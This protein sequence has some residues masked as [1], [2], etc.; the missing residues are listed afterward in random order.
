MA[1]VQ[2]QLKNKTDV[3]KEELPTVVKV[4]DLFYS[5]NSKDWAL[6]DIN[7]TIKQNQFVGIIG[8]NGGGKTTFIKLLLGI[9][10]PN[11]G[12]IRLFGKCVKKARRNIGYFPQI[13]N[14]DQ[15]FPI[16]VEQIILHARLKNKLFNFPSRKDKKVVKEVM[17]TLDIESFR[18]RRITELSGGQR[19]RVFLA[20]ALA[21][22]P[23]M[24]IL[25]E[26]MAGL[27]VTLQ[28]MFLKTLKTL[29]KHMTIIIIEHNLELLEDYVD[30]F[31]CLNQCVAHGINMHL[32]EH[33]HENSLNEV[34]DW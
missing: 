9:L 1:D 15:D 12:K 24:L 27:D 20:R 7:V 30:E 5:F 28:K 10:K 33:N 3:K 2:E 16:T 19:N 21:C 6:Q 31:V 17:N 22:E 32:I 8:P 18:D 4:D 14:M 11:L 25:D 29:N 34:K 13:K 26:P 23:K